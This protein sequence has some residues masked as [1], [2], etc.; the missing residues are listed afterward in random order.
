MK[1]STRFSQNSIFQTGFTSNFNDFNPSDFKFE[2]QLLICILR[3]ITQ[4]IFVLM[5]N[6]LF[7]GHFYTFFIQKC[8]VDFK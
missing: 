4:E 8:T 5:K 1:L 2:Q 3:K 7:Y 6:F